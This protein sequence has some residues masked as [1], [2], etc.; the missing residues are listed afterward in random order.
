MYRLVALLSQGFDTVTH[1][2]IIRDMLRWD[3]EEASELRIGLGR[4]LIVV[5]AIWAVHA[6]ANIVRH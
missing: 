5:A 6:M 2:L 4:T 1:A 3:E